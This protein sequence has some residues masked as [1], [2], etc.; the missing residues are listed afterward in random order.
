M[1]LDAAGLAP[2][3]GTILNLLNASIYALRGDWGAAGLSVL[4][5]VPVIGDATT[6]AKFAQKG[7]KAAKAAKKAEKATKTTNIGQ[8]FGTLTVSPTSTGVNN[9]VGQPFLSVTAKK[10]VTDVPTP[11]NTLK[12]G[13][14]TIDGRKPVS[15]QS[16][17]ANRKMTEKV[18]EK[19]SDRCSEDSFKE[20]FK[21][22]G[23]QPKPKDSGDNIY[24]SY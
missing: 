12:L 11:Q 3:V 20:I 7:V 15:I 9:N 14:L 23:S 22:K 5:A 2:G 18:V 19:K 16:P 21:Y 6:A 1:A 10:E 24:L 4:A 13:S 8:P 17:F